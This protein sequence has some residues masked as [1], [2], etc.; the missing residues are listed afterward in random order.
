M[1]WLE[2][3]GIMYSLNNYFYRLLSG[4]LFQVNLPHFCNSTVNVKLSSWLMIVRRGSIK[5]SIVKG[6]I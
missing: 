1:W 6:I 4:L 2:N 5:K 3:T